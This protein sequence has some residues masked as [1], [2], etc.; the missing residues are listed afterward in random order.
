MD[1]SAFFS[2]DEAGGGQMSRKRRQEGE[3]K[4]Q[5]ASGSGCARMSAVYGVQVTMLCKLY[6]DFAACG[7]VS[8]VV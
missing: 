3:R 7:S 8:E 1:R 6:G 5:P 4:S 2:G